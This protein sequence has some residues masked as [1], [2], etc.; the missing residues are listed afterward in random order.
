MIRDNKPGY[1]TAEE[2]IKVIRE[3]EQYGGTVNVSKDGTLNRANSSANPFKRFLFFIRKKFGLK[4]KDQIHER[5][6]MIVEVV[7][8]MNRELHQ[9]SSHV[10]N[11]SNLLKNHIHDLNEFKNDGRDRE[12][13]NQ[14]LI[15]KQT[16]ADA[17]RGSEK[18]Q[19]LLK[20]HNGK[21]I[22]DKASVHIKKQEPPRSS[23]IKMS[24]ST[25]START[26][27]VKINEA[28]PTSIEFSGDYTKPVIF[29]LT[30]PENQQKEIFS[31]LTKKPTFSPQSRS[32]TQRKKS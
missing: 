25:H 21:N 31:S 1:Q 26:I 28:L 30:L 6:A 5:K 29:M 3:A 17:E 24:D 7:S 27:T 13:Q 2:A 9:V 23:E 15:L 12:L 19:G 18:S 4:T 16:A 22:S 8:K 14:W 11:V 32:Q 20:S 10:E